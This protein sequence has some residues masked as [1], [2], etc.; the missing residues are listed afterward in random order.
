MAE[1]AYTISQIKIGNLL[2]NLKDTAVREK[3][4]NVQDNTTAMYQTWFGYWHL[5]SKLKTNTEWK[6]YYNDSNKI[7]AW[8]CADGVLRYW[9]NSSNG[10]LYCRFSTRDDLSVSNSSRIWTPGNTPISGMPT[11][12]NQCAIIIQYRFKTY[13]YN[14]GSFAAQIMR[15]YLQTNESL[16]AYS[17]YNGKEFSSMSPTKTT[18]SHVFNKKGV[19]DGSVLWVDRIVKKNSADMPINGYEFKLGINDYVRNATNDTP[20]VVQGVS[21]RSLLIAQGNTEEK[22]YP[23]EQESASETQDMLEI[24][25]IEPE[26]PSD[27][28]DE[29]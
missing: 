21:S 8:L 1:T 16:A 2:Y 13:F 26:E 7:N 17:S 20:P 12:V 3:L 4:K 10:K 15:R 25:T 19:L 24:D 18:F 23:N 22:L 5:N 27:T 28:P 9:I 14:T 29:E 11:V 6:N